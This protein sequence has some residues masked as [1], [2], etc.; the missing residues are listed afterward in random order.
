MRTLVAVYIWFVW[1]LHMVIMGPIAILATLISPHVGFWVVKV[2]SLSALG[3]AGIR[4]TVEGL[5]RVDWSRAHV[6][7]GNHQG[8]LDP[9]VFV[10]AIPRH[11]V[12]IEKKENLA[13][14]I[15]GLLA[16][17]WGNLPIDRSDAEAARRTIAE[18][19]ARLSRGTSIAIFPEGTRSV[20]GLI[21]PFKKGGFHLAINTGADIVPFT[22]TGSY[23]RLPPH[24]W[25][26]RP[27]T[28][29][30]AFG[31]AI[32]TA[33][34]TKETMEALMDEVKGAIAARFSA[35]APSQ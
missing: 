33:G 5:D 31:D 1:A 21:G 26:V 18:A 15:Y 28:V 23:E 2:G 24:E 22:L 14:P 30:L 34:H 27:G 6:L 32:P 29:T 35:P 19:E 4:V 8:I 25:R 12:G 10:I 17:A 3:L 7:M 16:R 11:M 13:I 9:F 20:T